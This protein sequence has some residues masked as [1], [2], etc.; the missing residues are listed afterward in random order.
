MLEGDTSRPQ[1]WEKLTGL[2]NESFPTESRLESPSLQ[3]VVHSGF[4][5]IEVYA[6]IGLG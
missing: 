4:A 1:I 3:L 5:T 2:L 6:R